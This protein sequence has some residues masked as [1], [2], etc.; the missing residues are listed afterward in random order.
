MIIM[1]FLFF[2]TGWWW[3]RKARWRDKTLCYSSHCHFKADNSLWPCNCE[4]SV[5][6]FNLTL[7][8]WISSVC[9]LRVL[10]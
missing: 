4:L 5:K 9:I 8:F 10:S 6:V 2:Q 7:M 1:L 3:R